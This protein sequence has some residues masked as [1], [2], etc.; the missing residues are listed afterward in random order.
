M[1][2][3]HIHRKGKGIPTDSLSLHTCRTRMFHELA[4]GDRETGNPLVAASDS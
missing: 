2:G 3:N 4:L 1:V